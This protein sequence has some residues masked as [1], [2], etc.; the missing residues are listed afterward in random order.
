M[1]TLYRWENL[2]LHQGSPQNSFELLCALLASR[3]QRFAGNPRNRFVRNGR[4]DGGVECYWELADGTIHGYQAKY[5]R[6]SLDSSQW[7]QLKDSIDTALRTHG[8]LTGVTV[9]LPQDLP[10]APIP[11]GKG[12]PRRTSRQTWEENRKRWETQG[13]STHDS[14]TLDLWDDTAIAAQLQTPQNL[15]LLNFFFDVRALT[16]DVVKT[17]VAA[18]AALVGPRY[19]PQLHVPH[20]LQA[21]FP[22]LTMT[23]EFR[24]TV[25]S[26][27]NSIRVLLRRE[28]LAVLA[29]KGVAVN[30]HLRP[31]A[32]ALDALDAAF[33][34]SQSNTITSLAKSLDDAMYD[35]VFSRLYAHRPQRSST[36]HGKTSKE[37]YVSEDRWRRLEALRDAISQHMEFFNSEDAQW[38]FHPACDY[39]FVAISGSGGCGKTHL[40]C[41]LASIIANRNHPVVLLLGQSLDAKEFRNVR[42]MERERSLT[43]ILDSLNIAGEV[44]QCRGLLIVDALNEAGSATEWKGELRVLASLLESYPNVT[45]LVSVR[46]LYEEFAL[47]ERDEVPK[48]LRVEHE[49]F[50]GQTDE[51][52]SKYCGHY[53]ITMPDVPTLNPEF[54]N[55]LFLSM[56]CQAVAGKPDPLHRRNAVPFP[57]GHMGFGQVFEGFIAFR[58]KEL[59]ARFDLD[60]DTSR[61]P[62]RD[63]LGAMAEKAAASPTLDIPVVDAVDIARA[64]LKS[65]RLQRNLLGVLDGDGLI[66]KIP[67]RLPD[68]QFRETVRFAYDRMGSHL[69]VSQWLKGHTAPESGLAALFGPS[70]RLQGVFD[71]PDR[72]SVLPSLCEQLVLLWPEKYHD[73]LFDHRGDFASHAFWRDAF[74]RAMRVS[75]PL[76]W[77]NSSTRWLR[78]SLKLENSVARANWIASYLC[79]VGHASLVDCVH[80]FLTE[81]P[82][83]VR[84]AEWTIWVNRWFGESSA[85]SLVSWP[86][87]HE[88]V[89]LSESQALAHL[90]SLA[91]LTVT[92]HRGLRA[93]ATKAMVAVLDGCLGASISLLRRFSAV[94][95]AYVLQ[96]VS[97]AVYGACLRS[98]DAT[99]ICGVAD[100]VQALW[101]TKRQFP[102]DVI[103]RHALSGIIE[104]AVHRNH[105]YTVDLK[106]VTPPYESE[107]IDDVLDWTTINGLT[108]SET[109]QNRY[110]LWSIVQSCMPQGVSGGMYGDFG[111]YKVTSA[112]SAFRQRRPRE[113][114]AERNDPFEDDLPHRY[115]ITRVLE[116]GWTSSLFEQFDRSCGSGDRGRVA[117]E[118]IGKKYQ[119]IALG[120]FLSKASDRFL[121]T[122]SSWPETDPIAYVCPADVWQHF[123]TDTSLVYLRTR[124]RVDD[125]YV[126]RSAAR[127]LWNEPSD[128]AWLLSEQ[129]FVDP[130]SYLIQGQPG[131]DRMSALMRGHRIWRQD[132]E[133]GRP[134]FERRYRT[135]SMSFTAFAIKPA[136]LQALETW[137]RTNKA[138]GKPDPVRYWDVLFGELFWSR[139][140][141]HV[142][143]DAADVLHAS[144][145]H[146]PLQPGNIPISLL[147]LAA[148]YANESDD[149]ADGRVDADVPCHW[150][151]ERLG[152]RAGPS[153]FKFTDTTG[154]IVCWQANEE[155]DDA[156][157]GSYIELN[158]LKA[159]LDQEGLQLVWWITGEKMVV[160]G[161]LNDDGPMIPF[162]QG[163]YWLGEDGIAGWS[164]VEYDIAFRE[165]R[166]RSYP[167]PFTLTEIYRTG[168]PLT[169]QSGEVAKS[170]R[171]RSVGRKRGCQDNGGRSEHG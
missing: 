121:L 107:W 24:T 140:A 57:G 145:I 11:R 133:E 18:Q 141:A 92:T 29:P 40:L 93:G 50:L 22:W 1:T 39:R 127:E 98:T 143:G 53:N 66:I 46:D 122:G 116:L 171:S 137:F 102:L 125:E 147:P 162:L 23:N 26:S 168:L 142:C 169:R 167:P 113:K 59:I 58:E 124:N 105:T 154:E 126:L 65:D 146:E 75:S 163:F 78:H 114:S 83:A 80:S 160:S 7:G 129:G 79:R 73:E 108:K 52:I 88:R 10:N 117:V 120:E 33:R 45:V 166:A 41:E 8:R 77:G 95:D 69:I 70:G 5:L 74:L 106:T 148:E 60:L 100:A 49:G 44:N 111:R 150:L 144:W 151:A 9:C 109:A 99:A 20:R 38:H 48:L 76:T 104:L 170:P 130:A 63:A 96:A 13:R 14:F 21:V 84:D 55:P 37:Q 149:M 3:D 128:N 16:P 67:R 4:P 72:D 36:D 35:R 51:A 89:R 97:L 155:D 25:V 103:S 17:H 2:Q 68:G 156:I 27:L 135:V 112:V 134:H 32:E 64:Y 54:D 132:L 56:F 110:A 153:E 81:Q 157:A 19:Q 28:E 161:E 158:R 30:E 138:N 71:H 61:R 101:P 87:E 139:S 152:L 85:T 115:I 15:S 94:N 82:L 123:F 12:K 86:L 43:Q 164:A 119:W 42:Y 91:W 90:T 34:S 47:P 118:R 31:V 6:D 136:D 62:L 159:L 165:G 131:T